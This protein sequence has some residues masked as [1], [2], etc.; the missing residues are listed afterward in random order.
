MPEAKHVTIIGNLVKNPN[1]TTVRDRPVADFSLAVTPE[2]RENGEIKKGD[3]VFYDVSVWGKEA[4]HVA[5]SLHKG[6]RAIVDGGLTLVEGQNRTF[7]NVTAY[8]VGA[9]LKF[10]DVEIASAAQE[11]S[12]A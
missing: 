5:K 4:E 9:S 3:T 11:Q 6:D 1:L 7:H 2:W 12:I 8:E 10:R